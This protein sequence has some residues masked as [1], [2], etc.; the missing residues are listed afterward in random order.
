M[1]STALN[2]HLEKL[3]SFVMVVQ[4]GSITKAAKALAISQAALSQS[5]KTLEDAL[6]IILLTRTKT[7]IV[8]TEEGNLLFQYGQQL[9]EELDHLNT[10]IRNPK[11]QNLQRLRIGTHEALAIH[12]WPEIFESFQAKNPDVFLSLVSGRVEMLVHQVLENKLDLIVTVKPKSVRGLT[13][14]VLYKDTFGFYAASDS[15]KPLNGIKI[16]KGPIDKSTLAKIPI[17]TDSQ[18]HL[19]QDQPVAQILNE[20]GLYS[21]QYFQLNSFQ[22]SIKLAAKGL[23]LAFLPTRIGDSSNEVKPINV[24]GIQKKTFDHS[25]C[26]SYANFPMTKN[27]MSL[28]IQ[29]LQSALS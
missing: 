2:Q 7:G 23:G 22:A 21:A 13:T 12:I 3:P 18:A 4:L 24:K 16:Q 10:R 11:K 29:H 20:V 9:L 8:P 17:L 19:A 1:Y 26:C 15:R 5:V 28:L 27:S 14:E 6:G 25:I